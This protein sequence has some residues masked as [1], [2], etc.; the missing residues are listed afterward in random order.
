LHRAGAQR[1]AA[2]FPLAALVA[3]EKYVMLEIT[4]E[5]CFLRFRFSWLPILTSIADGKARFDSRL[6]LDQTPVTE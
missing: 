6:C 4:H 1:I 3:A 5:Q 2:G